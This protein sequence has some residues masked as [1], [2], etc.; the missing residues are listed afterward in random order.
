MSELIDSHPT[1]RDWT[2]A[3]LSNVLD[4]QA[5]LYTHLKVI[6]CYCCY[7]STVQL[8]RGVLHSDITFICWVR[9]SRSSSM[10]SGVVIA[11]EVDGV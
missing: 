10:L 1:L 3:K 6:F 11:E 8:I 4:Y 7:T 5:V 2:G 9:S